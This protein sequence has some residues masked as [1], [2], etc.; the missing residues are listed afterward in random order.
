MT[1]AIGAKD[2]RKRKGTSGPRG[3]YKKYDT[4]SRG[5][6]GEYKKIKNIDEE[7]KEDKDKDQKIPTPPEDVQI[8]LDYFFDNYDDLNESEFEIS[9]ISEL[10][11]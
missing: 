7:D 11:F 8:L 9:D 3:P 1:R 4:S 6:R 2:K 5:K 10:D